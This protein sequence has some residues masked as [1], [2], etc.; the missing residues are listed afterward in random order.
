MT[1]LPGQLADPGS[2][3]TAGRPALAAAHPRVTSPHAQK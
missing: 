3:K 1:E 2:K